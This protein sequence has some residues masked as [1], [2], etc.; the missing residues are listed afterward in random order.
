MKFW[1]RIFFVSFNSFFNSGYYS[2][3][4]AATFFNDCQCYRA[5]SQTFAYRI[6]FFKRKFNFSNIFYIEPVSCI[7]C[8]YNN[9]FYLIYSIKLS[10]SSNVKLFSSS[11]LSCR[12]T[13]ISFSECCH[14]LFKRDVVFFYFGRVNLYPDLFVAPT[15]LRY[16]RYSF[17]IF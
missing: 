7:V 10:C 9:V 1:I 14:Y 17:Y 11:Y 13:H 2:Y 16:R 12:Y 5:C 15:T 3:C 6:F 4:I 8:P